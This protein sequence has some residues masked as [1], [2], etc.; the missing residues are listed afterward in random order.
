MF[1]KDE[2]KIKDLDV[3]PDFTLV[4][5]TYVGIRDLNSKYG[6]M[7]TQG[8]IILEPMYQYI[9]CFDNNQDV[10]ETV[11]NDRKKGLINK[12]GEI[13]LEPIYDEI[14]ESMNNKNEYIVIRSE[15]YK[16][17]YGIYNKSGRVVLEPKYTDYESIIFGDKR[18]FIVHIGERTNMRF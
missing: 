7:D 16:R 11:T 14:E 8:N 17:Y 15:N 9:T 13:I 5:D 10:L 1:S 6:L 2:K 18:I 4:G 3:K 12:N